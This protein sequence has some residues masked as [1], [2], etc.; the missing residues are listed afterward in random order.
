MVIFFFFVDCDYWFE[1]DVSR[2]EEWRMQHNNQ[3]LVGD[4][5]VCF[6][7]YF[8]VFHFDKE[9]ISIRVPTILP[10]KGGGTKNSPFISVEDP[11][12]LTKNLGKYITKNAFFFNMLAAFQVTPKILEVGVKYCFYIFYDCDICNHAM[13]AICFVI[14]YYY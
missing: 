7:Q 6:C 12:E 13:P 11:F 2:L 14:V 1:T 8:S 5:F 3:Q 9:I 10:V 4:L